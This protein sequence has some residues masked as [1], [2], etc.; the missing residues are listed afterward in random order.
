MYRQSNN[1][2]FGLNIITECSSPIVSACHD[3]VPLARQE[4]HYSPPTAMPR[5]CSTFTALKDSIFCWP[6]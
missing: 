2:L 6:G 4:G 1:V 5:S 3:S